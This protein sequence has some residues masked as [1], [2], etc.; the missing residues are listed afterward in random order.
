MSHGA[1]KLVLPSTAAKENAVRDTLRFERRR[2]ERHGLSGRATAVSHGVD[3]CTQGRIRSLQ[4]LNISDSGLGALC[5]DA[6]AP[7]TLITVFFPPHGP[8][9]GFDAIGRVVRCSPRD[10]GHE[11]GIRF[12]A[13]PAA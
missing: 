10:H 13:R 6:V 8:E 2:A 4:L 5:Q 9:R 1:L 12:D 11:V 7:D 3:D